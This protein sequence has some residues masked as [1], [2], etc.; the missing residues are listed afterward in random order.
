MPSD[1]PVS[2]LAYSTRLVK[3]NHVD[4]KAISAIVK[5]P[6]GEYEIFFENIVIAGGG[7]DNV[8]IVKEFVPS[9]GSSFQDHTSAEFLV[10]FKEEVPYRRIAAESHVEL[11]DLKTTH[12]GIES[13]VLLLTTEPAVELMKK[14]SVKIK[15]SNCKEFGQIWVQ[16]EIPPSWNLKMKNRE[17]LFYVDYTPYFLNIHLI[18]ELVNEIGRKLSKRVKVCAIHRQYRY[19]YGG[20]HLS[21]TTPIGRVVDENCKVIGT[22]NIYVAGTSVI[23]R[24]GGSGPSLTAVALSLR[25]GNLLL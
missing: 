22:Q 9:A 25:L 18:D 3:I 7:Y 23:P 1:I 8:A 16:I 6:D 2:N 4:G 5:D 19:H 12:S 24:A 13:K 21:G 10:K 15:K 11:E 17:D 20:F 14:S